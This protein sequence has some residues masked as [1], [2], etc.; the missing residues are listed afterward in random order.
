MLTPEP[1]VELEDTRLLMRQD[2]LAQ[3]K[4]RYVDLFDFAPIGYCNLDENGVIEE[5]NL[6]AA[7]LL[8]GTSQELMRQPFAEFL[9]P[10]D[11]DRFHEH[12]QRC[13]ETSQRMRI[14]LQLVPK[15]SEPVIVEL[16]TIATREMVHGRLQWRCA[17]VNLTERRRAEEALQRS[18]VELALRSKHHF[19]SESS[20]AFSATLHYETVL[21]NIVRMSIP[22]LA[23]CAAVDI[24][25]PDGSLVRSA[26]AHI[27]K[28]KEKLVLEVGQMPEDVNEAFGKAKV[29]RTG[30]SELYAEVPESLVTSLGGSDRHLELLRQIQ[31]RSFMCVPLMVRG[32]AIGAI[33]F[34]RIDGEQRYSLSDL[35]LAEEFTERAAMAIDNAMLYSKEQA[36]NDFKDRFMG[37]VSH[38]LKTPL[39]P[40]LGAVYRLRLIRANDQDIQSMADIVERSARKQ[41]EI[42]DDLLD[43]S[44]VMTGK[45]QLNKRLIDLSAVISGAVDAAQPNAA[46][47]RVQ[48]DAAIVP[49]RPISCDAERV[50]QAISKLV[51]NGIKF[52][53]AEGTVRVRVED[54]PSLVRI[55]VSDNGEGLA[56]EF[57]P[58]VFEP[59]RQADQFSTRS[60]GGLGLGLSLAKHIVTLHGG[61]IRVVSEGKG[62]GAT[63][64]VELPY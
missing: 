29:V 27:D 25:Q 37:M 54:E 30:R 3:S 52:S 16:Y 42:I 5:V 61:T 18:Q 50:Q 41:T 11:R 23:D 53:R 12:L 44:R 9:M 21:E 64:I 55:T 33:G 6:A 60:H 34:M 7:R 10:G 63:F 48:L 31:C 2:E 40:I 17:I 51:G 19:L 38:E 14:E 62:K 57:L 49:T 47:A 1:D 58:Y 36:V 13:R 32:K 59:F 24:V 28:A 4:L 22:Q 43:V 8:D 39:T 45:F 56:P 20:A 26:V 15:D 46:A 35:T